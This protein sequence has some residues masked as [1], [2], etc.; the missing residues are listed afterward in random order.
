MSPYTTIAAGLLFPL[1]ERLKGHDSPRRRRELEQTQW[2]SP[3]RLEA[4]RIRR[5]KAFLT[6]IGEQVPYYQRLFAECGFDPARVDSLDALADLPFLTKALIR[7]H[8]QAL[9]ADG[10]RG[11]ARFNTG[12]SSGEPL[13]F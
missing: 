11:L 8:T 4:L 13:I 5:L 1:H 12:G 10:A 2:W 3:Q 7:E 6:R 9:K